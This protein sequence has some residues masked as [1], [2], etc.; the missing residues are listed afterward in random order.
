ML[1]MLHQKTKGDEAV[2]VIKLG[3]VLFVPKCRLCPCSFN[4]VLIQILPNLFKSD[5]WFLT[6]DIIVCVWYHHYKKNNVWS[7]FIQN[8]LHLWCSLFANSLYICH[9]PILNNNF[10]LPCWIR[11]WTGSLCPQNPYGI[12]PSLPVKSALLFLSKEEKSCSHVYLFWK[13]IVKAIFWRFR[14]HSLL[15]CARASKRA[16]SATLL[17]G[18]LL[19]KA[20]S[21]LKQLIAI[22]VSPPFIP[23]NFPPYPLSS[24]SSIFL[25]TKSGLQETTTKQGK[26]KYNK[27][28]RKNKQ[29][30]EKKKSLTSK[31]DKSH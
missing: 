2:S 7:Q 17:G 23:L 10:Y 16:H 22:T 6:F 3:L 29:E 13:F 1:S 5:S 11:G 20:D 28:L 31:L 14:H 19:L 24:T 21:F 4:P 9:N 30:N 18:L 27:T 8:S 15:D 26:T 12:S 25:Q